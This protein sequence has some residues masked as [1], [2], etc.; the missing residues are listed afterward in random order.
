MIKRGNT[1]GLSTIVATLLIILL[2]L[3]AVA[4][5]WMV[6]RSVIKENAE[7]I[8]FG[9]F[10]VDL[11]ITRARI[12][13]DSAINVTVKRNPGDGEIYGILFIVYDENNSEIKRYNISL[14]ELQEKRFSIVLSDLVTDY[15]EKVAIAPIFMLESGKETVGDITDE[16]IFS[17]SSYVPPSEPP[18][19]SIPDIWTGNLFVDGGFESGNLNSWESTANFYVTTS[20]SQ[21]GTY[22]AYNQVS[23]I[24][25]YIRQDIDLISDST[26][27]SYIASGDARVNASI[28]ATSFDA[29]D[30]TRVQFI[31]LDSG[32]SQIGSPALDT[33]YDYYSD[34]E[35]VSLLNFEV[36]SNAATLRVWGNTYDSTAGMDSGGLDSFSV[37]LGCFD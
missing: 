32:G 18:S 33:G 19:Q 34:W 10:T 5:I 7:Q 1:K 11:D 17:D 30:R 24:T 15:V 13:N 14:A 21:S 37:Y 3:V 2:T 9:K 31:F 29:N 12:V 26:C 16:W 23:T 22:A 27:G 6:L 8:S 25:D 36:P 4:I 35:E 28:Y 20:N